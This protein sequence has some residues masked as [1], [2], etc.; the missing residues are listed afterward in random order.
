MDFLCSLEHIW[1]SKLKIKPTYTSQLIL[2]IS[3]E[4]SLIDRCRLIPLNQDR[5]V[6]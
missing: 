2:V 5:N 4:K 6:P 1:T 3:E